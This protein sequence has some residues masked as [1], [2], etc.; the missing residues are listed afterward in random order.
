MTGNTQ[1]PERKKGRLG[2]DSG[3]IFED[4]LARRQSVD[5]DRDETA[6][7]IRVVGARNGDAALFEPGSLADQHS[8]AR[9]Q[10]LRSGSR[11]DLNLRRLQAFRAALRAMFRD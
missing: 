1:S 6:A 4:D 8:M 3:R 5:G 10:P 9:Y 7:G 2:F 11:G